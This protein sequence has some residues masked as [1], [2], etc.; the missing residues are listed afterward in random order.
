MARYLVVGSGATGVHVAQTLLERGQTVELVDVGF[1]RPPAPHPD[2][3]FSRLKELLDD[4]ERYFLGDEGSAVVY[5]APDA[6]PYGFPPSKGYVFR[7][8]GEVS[9]LERG[10]SPIVSYA[11]GGLAEAWTGGSYELRDEELAAEDLGDDILEESG[12][13]IDD[14]AEDDAFLPDDEDEEDDVSGIIRGVGD[15]DE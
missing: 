7:R 8:P 11:R 4:P 5:P 15:E 10:F 1:E 12:E 14:A 13:E 3:D 9:I 6:K 2:A